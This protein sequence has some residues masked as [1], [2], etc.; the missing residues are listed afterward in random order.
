[1]E[2]VFEL[3]R[4]VQ[5]SLDS[6]LYQVSPNTLTLQS[7]KEGI[8]STVASEFKELEKEVLNALKLKDIH[9]SKKVKVKYKNVSKNPKEKLV[10]GQ[11]KKN[12]FEPR[13][14]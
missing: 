4:Q 7:I 5:G 6:T 2:K 10:F 9:F 8:E 13:D 3:A 11:I 1:V 14:F 12:K